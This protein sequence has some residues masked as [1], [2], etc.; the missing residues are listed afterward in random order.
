MKKRILIAFMLTGVLVSCT[1]DNEEQPVVD[2]FN[3]DITQLEN[4]VT[5]GEYAPYTTGS[6]FQYKQETIMGDTLVTWTVLEEKKIGDKY[7]IEISG[8]L[9]ASNNGYFNCE[10]GDYTCYLPATAFTP[11]IEMVYMKENVNVG[12]E[13]EK[14]VD[15]N[16]GGVVFQTRYVFSYSAKMDSYTVES[17]TYN[18]VIHI[19]LVTTTI[20]SGIEIPGSEDDYFWAKGVGLVEKTG[21]A[22]QIT[23]VSYNIQ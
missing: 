10:G 14:L 13:W 3:T 4:G 17:N 22:G 8:F 1:K 12:A 21:L 7:F 11:V 2:S 16:F 23:L 19:H 5:T 6:T 18:D 20:M 15:T 9:G